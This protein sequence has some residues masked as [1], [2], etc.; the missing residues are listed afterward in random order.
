MVAQ[1]FWGQE[2]YVPTC[3]ER[4]KDDKMSSAVHHDAGHQVSLCAIV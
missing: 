3:R 2:L 1:N 4:T